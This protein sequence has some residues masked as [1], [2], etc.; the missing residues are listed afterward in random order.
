[1]AIGRGRW[2]LS[3][4]I[5]P[6]F[7]DAEEWR[8]FADLVRWARHDR[9]ILQEPLPIG[10]DP[11]K[12][13]AYGYSFLGDARQVY[14]LRNPWI[15]ET[16]I[17]LAKPPPAAK[18][19]IE[20][21]MLYPRRAVFART[22]PGA[23]LPEVPLGPYETQFI[24]VVPADLPPL[25]PPARPEPAVAWCAAREPW[26][27]CTVFAPDPPALGPSWTSPDGE[28]GRRT[29][30]VVE[31]RLAVAGAME[32]Q[33]SILTEGD[34]AVGEDTCRIAIDGKEA[35][36][37]VSG[38]KGAFGAAGAG[39]KEHW[40]WFLA[41]VPA[42]EHEV[43]IEVAGPALGLPAGVFLRG[44]VAAPA[45]AAPF[46]AGPAFPLWRAD[47]RP[48]SRVLVPLAARKADPARTRTAVREVVRIDGVY[49]DALEWTEASAGWGSA[50]KNRSIME[51]PLTLGGKTF[52]RGI[53]S[54]ARSRIVWHVPE[55]H[56]T[57]AATIGK[58][59]EVAGGSV[60]FAV[61]AGGGEVFRSGV[62][63]DDTPPQEISVP[64]ALARELA[65]VVDDAGDGIAAD[66]ADWADA[67]LLRFDPA[68]VRREARD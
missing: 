52:P 24:E 15:E 51:K 56:V 18:G 30:L 4:Y 67:R 20:V 25:E 21:R 53:G 59:Q 14:C 36:V 63:R 28:A 62:F 16:R 10:G 64:I 39:R 12:R 57:F 33:L 68:A 49:L 55:G 27:E 5:D 11:A 65:L 8:F 47:R 43:R 60:T 31:G 40:V 1:M 22:P 35:A 61:E 6:R 54:H 23:A 34:P 44:R 26:V 58:D 13:E 48:W 7:M 46:D 19:E 9:A 45:P 2:F 38:S 42:G 29:S 32:S 17:A 3:S 41:D 66:H 50:R 37:T